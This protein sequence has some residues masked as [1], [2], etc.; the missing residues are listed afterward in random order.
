[1]DAMKLLKQSLKARF[2]CVD[3]RRV[4]LH[5]SK[6]S[7]HN[8][9]MGLEAGVQKGAQVRAG[10]DAELVLQPFPDMFLCKVS[11]SEVVVHASPNPPPAVIE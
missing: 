2:S 8:G 5:D 7:L 4:P 9:E 3:L 1:M 11:L 6:G 10:C